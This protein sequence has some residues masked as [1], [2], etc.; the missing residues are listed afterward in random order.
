PTRAPRRSSKSVWANPYSLS[1]VLRTLTA[2]VRSNGVE[3]C[4]RRG[5]ITIRMSSASELSQKF[6]RLPETRASGAARIACIIL[7]ARVR[8]LPRHL[9]SWGRGPQPENNDAASQ[10]FALR[11]RLHDPVRR[12]RSTDCDT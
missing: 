6:R 7:L 12:L 3:G 4:A 9:A 5:G 2:I 1:S 8:A 10:G 11:C